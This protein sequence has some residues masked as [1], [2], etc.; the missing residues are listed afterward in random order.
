MQRARNRR[1]GQSQHVDIGTQ[2]LQALLNLDSEFLFFVDNQ[3]AEISKLDVFG[4][5]SMCADHDIDAALFQAFED[6][7]LFSR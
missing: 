5:Q 3:Q 4:D 1:G 6:A 7:T 2:L